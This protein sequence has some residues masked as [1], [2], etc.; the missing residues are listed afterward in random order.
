M[1][2]R[3]AFL[4]GAGAAVAL[5]G[6]AAPAR[7]TRRA[8]APGMAGG[9][10]GF[11]GAERYQ[12]EAASAE[13][14]AIAG[15]RR[16]TGNG[17]RPLTVTLLLASGAAGHWTSPYPTPDA[18]SPAQLLEQEAGVRLRLVA[19]RPGLAYR[20][21]LQAATSR[22]GAWT[23]VQV[24][25]RE[26]GDLAAAGLLRDLD[27]WVAR[28]RPDWSDPLR[29]FA[30]GAA[31]AA[32]TGT[33]RGSTHAVALDGDYQV[34]VYRLDLFEDPR[35]QADFRARHGRDLRFP[36][37]W[38]EH[39]QVAEFFT[40][41]DAG[42]YGSTDLKNP[43]WGYTG[44][45]QRYVSA[46]APN[47]LYFDPATARPLIDGPEG[48]RATQEHVASLSWTYP[49]ALA[50]GWQDQYASL[51][52][53]S[54]AMSSAFANVTRLVAPGGPLDGGYADRLRTAVAPGRAVDGAVVHRPLL[55]FNAQYGVNAHAGRTLQE[56][57]YL[58]LQWASGARVASWMV[59]S[60]AAVYDPVHEA[61]LDDPAV[62]AAYRPEAADVL[63]QVIPR[64]AP[65]IAGIRGASAYLQAL[66]AQLQ[67]ALARKV[68]PETAMRN[69]ARHWEA[70]TNRIGRRRQVEALQAYGPA[71]PTLP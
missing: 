20:K 16:L 6:V 68:S 50:R 35:N 21:A 62:R 9:P 30:G 65:E 61:S 56:A 43:L 37:T 7:A 69:A 11:P 55:A 28:Y 27:E 14:R 53:G 25:L 5:G 41:P 3:R 51:G 36:D 32:Q 57:A 66:D 60:P 22:S 39:A 31:T 42:L 71:W 8:L 33:Y 52:A 49:G 44:W 34:W 13:G 15:L 18:P 70:I 59:T 26:V 64:A 46:A 67:N 23:I 63:K 1:P 54:A 58:V 45:M 40:R 38:E 12:Y 2:T 47:Q 4:R 17:R 48:V 29:G 19:V 24:A 10:T